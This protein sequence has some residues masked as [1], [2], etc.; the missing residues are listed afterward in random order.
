MT[1]IIDASVATKWVLPEADS[2]KAVALRASDNDIIAPSLVTAEIGNAIWKSA[3]WGDM[4][5]AHAL[6]ALKAAVAHYHRL[7]PI[8]ELM[9]S[10]L[11]FATNLRHPIYDCFYLALAEREAATLV[12]ADARLLAAAKKTKVNVRAL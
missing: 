6:R 3:M 5:G 7:L 9:P 8:E 12:T 11:A 4:D 1:L 10:A 2:N